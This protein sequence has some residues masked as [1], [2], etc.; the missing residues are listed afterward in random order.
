[1]KKSP[2][3]NSS[4]SI[5]KDEVE[6]FSRIAEEWWDKEGKFSPLHK[7]NPV[8]TSYIK[9]VIDQNKLKELNILD[10][11]CGGGLLSEEMARIGARVTAIDASERN[12]KIATMHA[13]ESGLNINYLCTS[14]EDL[15]E[16]GQQFDMILNMEVIEHVADVSSFMKSACKLLKPGGFIF[17]ATL[18]RSVK[19][20]AFAIIGA[21]Y[22][23]KWLPQG[24]HDWKKFL[25]PSEV[26]NYLAENSVQVKEIKGVSYSL[27][28]N[29]WD[30]SND[31]SVNYMILAQKGEM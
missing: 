28:L 25:K 22:V 8:R 11:G 19:S 16:S 4:L 21:E 30:I 18:N 5:D 31:I 26:A 9:E 3:I 15:A 20:F 7:L 17:I 29:K 2:S 1:M 12:I 24:T 6:K 10:I 27:L 13:Q 23:L 14:I